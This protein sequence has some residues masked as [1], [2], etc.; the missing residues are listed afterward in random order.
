[1]AIASQLLLTRS[2]G[3]L[4]SYVDEELAMPSVS[5]SRTLRGVAD[6]AA[7]MALL[8]VTSIVNWEQHV[9]LRCLS[10]KLEHSPAILTLAP[11]ATSLVSNCSGQTT[12]DLE[13]YQQSI[14]QYPQE[15][16]QGY[17]LVTDGGP[18]A[19][20]AFGLA[21]HLRNQDV[22]FS[23]IPFTDPA[24][25]HSPNSVFAGVP[26]GTQ[27]ALPNG[28]YNPRIS[29][30]N[31]AATPAHVTVSIA[32]TQPGDVPV[33]AA[34]GDSPEKVTIRQL[35]IAPRRSVELA[36]SDAVSQSGLLQSL[37]VETDRK[38]GEVLGKAVSRSDGSFFE[39]ELLEKDQMD[40]NNGGI[41]PWSVEGDFESHL[42]LFNY[43]KKPQVFGVGISNGAILWDKKYTLA[44]NETREISFNELIQDKVRD[45]K[46]RTL[47]PDQQRGV[48]N[49]MVPDSGEGTGRL[50]VTSRSRGMARNFSCGNFTVVCGMDFYTYNSGILP[51]GFT[52]ALWGAYPEFCSAWS[53]GEC[54]GGNAEDSGSATY[55]WT[56]GAASIIT[57]TSSTSQSPSVTGVSPG[58]GSGSVEVEGGGCG[59]QGT[60]GSTVCGYSITPSIFQAQSCSGAK[61]TSRATASLAPSPEECVWVASQS[62]CGVGNTTG[63]VDLASDSCSLATTSPSNPAFQFAYFAGPG[64]S[65]ST[66]GTV[67]VEFNI[68][69]QGNN[70]VQ[71]QNIK[72]QCP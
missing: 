39:V 46:G 29:F 11:N 43:S 57:P 35:T 21:P 40:E 16:I 27:Q 64:S 51:V 48:V 14:S 13:S 65:G 6:N 28:V 19:I 25:I 61:N 62:S 34:P 2:R 8:A 24:E 56:I 17:E 52:D 32:A 49:W 36:L 10:E 67:E 70:V 3:A 47:S 58:S 42:L 50:M 60:G 4:P 26:F 22:V 68:W 33:S 20:A 38:P 23:A 45:G 71:N 63:T 37:F 69:M 41:H 44:P 30:T 72:V 59:V 12:T 55:S 9:T 7:G 1:M 18:G 5:G 15:G 53:P 54:S 31:F 66:A